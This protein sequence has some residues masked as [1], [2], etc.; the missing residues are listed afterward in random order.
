MPQTPQSNVIGTPTTVVAERPLADRLASW[1]LAALLLYVISAIAAGWRYFPGFDKDHAWYLQVALRVSQGE[2]LYRDVAWQYGPLPA[3]A[4]AALFRWGGP[5]AAWASLI[6]GALAVAGVLLTY[7]V[8]RSLL[9]PG[10]A[11][12]VTAF[13]TL[14]GPNLWGGLFHLYFYVYTQAIAWGGVASL[15]T[16][17]AVLRWQ[18]TRRDTWLIL[19]GLAT[20]LAVLSKPEFGVAALA[21]SGTAVIVGRGSLGAW[22]RYL[23]ASALTAGIGFGLQAWSAGLWPVWRGY[24]GYDQLIH[25]SP[26]LWGIRLG[27][28]SFLVGSYALWLAV[29]AI[30]ASRRWPRG[31]WLFLALAVA[32]AV[33]VLAVGLSYLLGGVDSLLSV[34]SRQGNSDGITVTPANVLYLVALLWSPLP[35]LL[36]IA[37]GLARG[38]APACPENRRARV[39]TAWW[40]IWA[41]ALVASLRPFLTGYTNPLAVAPALA[42]FWV[43]IEDRLSAKPQK[44]ARGRRA[45]LFVLV[46]LTVINLVAQLIVPNPLFNGPRVEQD[47]ALGSVRIAQ[48]YQPEYQV[49]T[50][51]IEQHVPVDAPIFTAVWAPQWY[52]LT[53]HPNPTAFDLFLAGLGTSGPEAADIERDLLAS[54]PAAVI[55]PRSWQLDEEGGTRDARETRQ[56]LPIWWQSLLL[57]YVDRTPPEVQRWRVFLRQPGG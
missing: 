21:A 18:R 8:V 54:P 5:D 10:S 13:A 25:G 55:V 51:F 46:G 32:A 9:S 16:L 20:G 47:T 53:K 26:W 22:L 6:N 31:R 24:T 56:N 48:F 30:W 50:G 28:R 35:V 43:V 3:Q 14:A 2:T 19:A 23:L 11:F 49:L 39:P 42:V 17:A 27:S 38:D 15:A 4:L 12:L 44:L 40:A 29:G 37:G 1:G 33:T 45:A 57:D 7:I 41:Y 52:L 36:L 34:V